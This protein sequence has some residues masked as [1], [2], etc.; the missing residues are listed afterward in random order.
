MNY[1]RAFPAQFIC[2]FL[3]C[4]VAMVDRTSYPPGHEPEN[5]L[6]QIFGQQ[7]VDPL[8]CLALTSKGIRSVARMAMIAADQSGLEKAVPLL[9]GAQLYGSNELEQ[10]LAV[11]TIGAF[12]SA[13]R[14]QQD[15]FNQR[16]ARME[17]DP[18]KIPEIAS[19][20]HSSFRQL[21]V[22]AHPDVILDE[23]NEPHRKLVEKISRDYL[24]NALVPF[25]ELGELRVRADVILAKSGMVKSAEELVKIAHEDSPATVATVEEVF[26][27]LHAFLVA[28][29]Y[30]NICP[31]TEAAGPL[32]YMRELIAFR[33]DHNRLDVL[34][35]ADTLIRKKVAQLNQDRR[36][37]FSTLGVA[38]HE[39]LMNYRY[40]WNDAVAK[41]V[42]TPSPKRGKGGGG[43]HGRDTSPPKISR[44]ARKK[45]AAKVR[46]AKGVIKDTKQTAKV[47][48]KEKGP[49]DGKVVAAKKIPQSEFKILIKLRTH[50][51]TCRFFNASC[52][53][54]RDGCTM[55]HKCA[56]CG[57][58]H[59]WFGNCD[60]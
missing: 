4:L 29:E 7:R 34:V 23:W 42:R 46:A 40:L 28:L 21:F 17:E 8:V 56:K 11:S 35:K 18:H 15:Q 39:V 12:W 27:R 3:A 13:A 19:D 5:T 59:P 50:G 57:G 16:R 44:N 25:Y 47:K 31:F 51:V 32:L 10:L 48:G 14:T 52:G 41:R 1:F 45:A 49:D 24:V 30:L 22:T 26:R 20:D 53:C 38:L 60:K 54:T 58:D 2:Q 9:L 37:Q 55:A 6:R 36:A 33:H 43:D